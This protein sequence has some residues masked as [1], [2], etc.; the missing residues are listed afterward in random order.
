MLGMDH[1]LMKVVRNGPCFVETI[2]H[3]PCFDESCSQNFSEDYY[4]TLSVS[5]LKK[6]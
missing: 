4:S 2:W 6:C 1:A 3:G 5:H